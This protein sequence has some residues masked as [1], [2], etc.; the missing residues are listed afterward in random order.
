MQEG[1]YTS[2]QDMLISV[3]FSDKVCCTLSYFGSSEQKEK[4]AFFITF[5]RI[6]KQLIV[7]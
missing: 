2:M 6:Y 5:F 1:G 4:L 3:P 7:S